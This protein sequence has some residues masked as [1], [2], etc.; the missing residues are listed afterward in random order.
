[1]KQIDRARFYKSSSGKDVVIKL[2]NYQGK[3]LCEGRVMQEL[4]QEDLEDEDN[5]HNIEIKYTNFKTWEISVKDHSTS[6]FRYIDWIALE[7]NFGIHIRQIGPRVEPVAS[8][9]LDKDEV[10]TKAFVYCN[11]EGL[12]TKT[13]V[14]ASKK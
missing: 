13:Y 1:M 9:T 7:T 6:N 12:F 8:F 11:L 10:P 14:P 4:P 3:L 5:K 2:S